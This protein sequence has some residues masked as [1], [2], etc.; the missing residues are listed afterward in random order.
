MAPSRTIRVR[1]ALSRI[2]QVD[3]AL[4]WRCVALC[5]QAS[6]QFELGV[7]ERAVLNGVMAHYRAG[8]PLDPAFKLA[9][10]TI[11]D[12]VRSQR[13]AGQLDAAIGRQVRRMPL[14]RR[15][16]RHVGSR[17]DAQG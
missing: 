10:M 14:R 3:D 7:A 17:I 5:E 4:F 11:I 9:A 6:G 1:D 15:R 13:R 16:R 8:M 12:E 2:R